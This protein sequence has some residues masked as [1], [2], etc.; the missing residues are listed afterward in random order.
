MPTDTLVAQEGHRSFRLIS[1]VPADD[2]LPWLDRPA[3]Y[4]DWMR[5]PANA[6]YFA[7]W[8]KDGVVTLRFYPNELIEPYFRFD[9]KVPNPHGFP[10]PTG[11]TAW[12]DSCLISM[13][14]SF[15]TWRC[16]RPA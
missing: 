9:R 14:R 13:Y 10:N 16:I 12:P 11:E 3:A 5:D 8:R 6:A 4:S 15:G 7:E 1:E 2:K